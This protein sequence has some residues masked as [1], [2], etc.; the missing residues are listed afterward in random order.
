MTSVRTPSGVWKNA[1][2]RLP[3]SASITWG[4]MRKRTPASRSRG[5]LLVEIV[6]LVHVV[7][8]AVRQR[9]AEEIL[10]RRPLEQ[11]EARVAEAEQGVDAA[12]NLAAQ[13]DLCAERVGI[14]PIAG[15]ISATLIA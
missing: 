11:D 9:P 3:N 13:P 12:Q 7:Q 6:D 10:I 14:N 4:S 2:R 5:D 15:S 8:K 1:M